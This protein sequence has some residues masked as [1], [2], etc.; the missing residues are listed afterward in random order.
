MN[1]W[2]IPA[3]YLLG[4]IPIAWLLT[5]LL[6]GQ[7]LRDL[8]SGNVGVMNTALSSARWAG[9]LVFLAEIAKGVLAVT[10]SRA[11]GANDMI[12]GL[13]IISVVVGTRYPIWLGFKGGRGNTAGISAL[14]L[15]AWPAIAIA[16]IVWVLTRIITNNSFAATRITLL[17]LPI[18]IGLVTLSIEYTITATVLSLIY[19]STQVRTTDDHTIINQRWD[20]MWEFL[21]S[22]PRHT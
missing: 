19:L 15:I 5:K 22:P 18:S 10:A 2:L 8:G 3:G 6:T 20:S 1:I 11:L 7:D 4:S 17:S 12:T 14:I 9:L 16:G 13:T 21:I